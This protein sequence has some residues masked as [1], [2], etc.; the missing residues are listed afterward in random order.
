V[1]YYDVSLFYVR[2]G[3]NNDPEKGFVSPSPHFTSVGKVQT[4]LYLHAVAGAPFDREIKFR[5]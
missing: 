2:L 5:M 3:E 1:C 4:E